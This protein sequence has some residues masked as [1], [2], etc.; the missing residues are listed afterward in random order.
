MSGWKCY[1]EREREDK[2]NIIDYFRLKSLLSKTKTEPNTECVQ[3]VKQ[4][5]MEMTGRMFTVHTLQHFR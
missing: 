3:T 4:T 2:D 1:K 5:D